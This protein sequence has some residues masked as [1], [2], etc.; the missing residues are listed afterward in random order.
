MTALTDSAA[1]R[2]EALIRSHPESPQGVYFGGS[3]WT[4]DH[5]DSFAHGIVED[6]RIIV[7]REIRA[8]EARGM[9]TACEI[10]AVRA[11]EQLALS[12]RCGLGANKPTAIRLCYAADQLA[13]VAAEIR[14]AIAK[15]TP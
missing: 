3:A 7:A 2:A 12:K 15:V 6:M 11:A 5:G 9:E 14:A 8:A 10:I 1:A 4:L 13:T